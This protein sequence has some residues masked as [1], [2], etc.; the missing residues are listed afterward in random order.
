MKIAI[1]AVDD[2]MEALIDQRFGRCRYFLVVD[3]EGDLVKSFQSYENQGLIQG[4]GA[5]IRAAQQLGELKVEKVITGELGPNATSVLGQLGIEAYHGSGNAEDALTDFYKGKLKPITAIAQPH[6]GLG[7]KSQSQEQGYAQDADAEKKKDRIFFP[8]LSDDGLDSE[9]SPHF[10]HAPKFGIY[11]CG[12]E[13][14]QVNDNDLVHTDPNKSPVDQVIEL[15]GPTIVYAL[16]IGGRAITLFV[17]KGI[18]VKTGG[19]RTPREVI[20]NLDKI[21]DQ[22]KSCSEGKI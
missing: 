11:D 10:G 16:G 3:L 19:F 12:T 22:D 4:H 20:D 15:A 14:F 5:G 13:D 9:I 6:S 1:T 21:E 8:L 17:K 18:K 7:Q 2:N